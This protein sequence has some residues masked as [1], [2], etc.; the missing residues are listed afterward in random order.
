MIWGYTQFSEKETKIATVTIL[1]I[2]S[3]CSLIFSWNRS[4]SY[5][6]QKLRMTDHSPGPW[7]EDKL[8]MISRPIGGASCNPHIKSRYIWIIYD[9][10]VWWFV[11]PS[12]L[13]SFS[14]KIIKQHK[15]LN[16]KLTTSNNIHETLLLNIICSVVQ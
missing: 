8:R 2:H 11:Q 12:Y 16:N 5:G 6:Q 7:G 1:T 10:M 4:S 3:W 14:I 15:L 9:D 13:V